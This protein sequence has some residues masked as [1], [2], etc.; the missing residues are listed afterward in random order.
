MSFV[1]FSRMNYEDYYYNVETHLGFQD[2][3]FTKEPEEIVGCGNLGYDCPYT[4]FIRESGYSGA[5]VGYGGIF[6]EN[7]VMPVPAW[8]EAFMSRI[9]DNF[10]QKEVSAQDAKYA[11]HRVQRKEM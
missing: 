2:W 5:V 7:E 4:H 3:L 6:L 10:D 8:L 11:L 1:V 9:D